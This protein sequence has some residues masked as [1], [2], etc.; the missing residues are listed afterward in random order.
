MATTSSSPTAAGSAPVQRRSYARWRAV[1]LIAVHVAIGVHIAHWL[2]A[3]RSLAPLEFNEVVYTLE[4]GLVTAGFLLMVTAVLATA[5]FGRFFC[6]WACHILALQD[7]CSWLLGKAGIEAKPV[8]SRLLRAAP[9]VVM[10]YMFVWPQLQRLWDGRPL[11]P[12]HTAG[13]DEAWASFVTEQFWRNLPGPWITVLTFLVCGFV[14]VYVLGSRA[15]CLSGCP[16]GAVFA[17]ADRL[18]PGRIRLRGPCTDCG[19]CTA[20]CQSGIW[21]H[22]EV[23]RFHNVVDPA[24][25]RDFD[26]IAAC[27]EGS[28]SFGFGKPSGFAS[29]VRA[30]RKRRG[31]HW[32]LGQDLFAGGVVLAVTLA[33]RGLYDAVPFLMA[34]GLGCIAAAGSLLMLRLWR[35]R[36]LT[37]RR[38]V[39]RRADRLTLAGRI[40][41]VVAAASV[42]FVA[43]SA[44]VRWHEWRGR[45]AFEAAG[46][47]MD[48]GRPGAAQAAVAVAIGHHEQ[49]E[50]WGLW[51]PLAH[52]RRLVSL[53]AQR[54]DARAAETHLRRIVRAE[55]EDHE[56]R[57]RLATALAALDRVT[58]SAA[59][60]EE[61]ARRAA[62]GGVPAAVCTSAAAWSERLM[63]KLRENG[64]QEAAERQQRCAEQ[65]RAAAKA[66]TR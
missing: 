32:P 61:L 9:W 24:C 35:S 30:G 52:D 42:L 38:V 59:E 23:Q 33:F 49:V 44:W 2:V 25:L 62:L 19:R 31:F 36:D 18:A 21:V 51:N 43:D 39:L 13:P 15:F 5:V 4:L 58:E 8:R 54:G 10:G 11:P 27:P 48:Q 1:T 53:Y 17:L 46:A 37:W 64:Q 7:L 40:A 56:A 34:V 45:D 41:T 60:L 12:V 50:R 66:S 47:A 6:G 63:V 22:E 3:G 26:C 28:L 29:L 16:Y 14:I 55:P 57:A 65:L 20:A